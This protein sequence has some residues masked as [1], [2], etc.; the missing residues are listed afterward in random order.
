MSVPSVSSLA[1]ELVTRVIVNL[2]MNARE[3][4]P[5]GGRLTIAACEP[6]FTTR[7]AGGGT[8]LGLSTVLSLV[9]LS[10][11]QVMLA[12]QPGN[13]TSARLYLPAAA[14]D[15]AAS[16][17]PGGGETILLVED[18]AAVRNVTRQI[19]QRRGYTVLA[20]ATPDEALALAAARETSID[21]LLSDVVIPEISGPKLARLV[22]ALRPGLP[23]VFVSGYAED[24]LVQQMSQIEGAVFLAKPV[25]PE[26]LL[27]TLRE[28]LDRH[29]A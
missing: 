22:R 17:A 24:I 25:D 7:G 13:G 1:D 6:L 20:A 28:L 23:V 18:E 14:R 29:A 19:L 3:A 8:G 26:T 27:V 9:Q 12:S 10:G 16:P 15:D 5:E 2:V 11:G 21:L 4:M